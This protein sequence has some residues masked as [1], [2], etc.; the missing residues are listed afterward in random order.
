MP[1][2]SQTRAVARM[3]KALGHPTR[4]GIVQMLA[5]NERCVC[6]IVTQ[7]NDSQATVS[8]HLDVL[9]KAGIVDR[10]KDGVKMI[11]RLAMPC[12]LNAMPCI[13]DALR[14]GSCTS[15]AARG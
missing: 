9:L 6:E 7:Y 15:V 12:I 1:P 4:L 11:Y 14:T 10:R 3:F 5:E 8:R 2:V 13:V